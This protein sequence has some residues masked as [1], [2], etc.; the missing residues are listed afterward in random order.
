MTYSFESVNVLSQNVFG[1]KPMIGICMYVPHLYIDVII[2][3]ITI[4]GK[5]DYGIGI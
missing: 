1:N 3:I 5:F 4:E 2:K